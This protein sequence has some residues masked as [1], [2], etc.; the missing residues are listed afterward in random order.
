MGQGGFR[1]RYEW[2]D[3]RRN[4]QIGKA[5]KER[6]SVTHPKEMAAFRD[7]SRKVRLTAQY[8]KSGTQK[9][10]WRGRTREEAKKDI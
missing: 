3:N 5:E 7:L 4:R 2:G 9:G 10:I 1:A 8:R 6:Y